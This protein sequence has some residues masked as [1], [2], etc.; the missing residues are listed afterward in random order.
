MASFEALQALAEV[1]AKNKV[2]HIQVIG[3][4]DSKSTKFEAFYEALASG[5]VQSDEVAA[6]CFYQ[7]APDHAAYRKLK[8]RLQE[9]LVN[10]LFFIDLN[11]SNFNDYTRAYYN[12]YKMAAAT[13]ILIG[14]SARS[15]ATPL[16][17][18]TLEIALQFDITDVA[19]LM[20]KELRM[21]YG[22]MRSAKDKYERINLI[23]QEQT[24]ILMAELK[25][26]QY[27]NDLRVD[28]IN[29]NAAKPEFAAKAQEYSEELFEL[30]K[31]IHSYR[32][33]YMAY[34]IRALRYEVAGDYRNMLP[35]CQEALAYFLDKQQ[36]VP[37]AVLFS[38][39]IRAVVCLIQ[40]ERYSEA[41]NYIPKCL[42]VVKEGIHNWFLALN[43]H[44]ILAFYSGNFQEAYEIGKKAIDHPKL[45]NQNEQTNEQWHIHEAYLYYLI[46][47]GK[48]SPDENNPVKKFRL[49]KFINE[50]PLYKKD[51]RG[52]NVSILILQILFLLQQKRYDVI[53]DRIESLKAYTQRYLRNDDTFR[54]SC[55]IRMLLVMAESSF[56]KKATIR[57]AEKYW[58]KLREKPINIAEQS[59]EIE[60]VPYEMLWE[61]VLESLDEKWY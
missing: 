11:Q 53:I 51:K 18:K 47:I 52:A 8:T 45:K 13:R 39:F 57:K 33:N 32:F 54:S 59:A 24:N 23:L 43:Y 60:I 48:I 58:E 9:R 26:E 27:L 31:S 22:T 5:Q 1:V 37:N 16:A 40:L 36:I 55:F 15:A 28:F 29:T 42:E 7:S 12:C 35:V 38:F 46:S 61:F 30:S 10:T 25:A 34:A 4:P 44:M 3:N 17:E 41:R 21:H 50:V 14:R 56:N 6:Q 20:A 49:G 19:F 2:K